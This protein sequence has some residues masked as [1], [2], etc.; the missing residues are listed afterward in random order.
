M[1]DRFLTRLFSY[2]LKFGTVKKER[3]HFSPCYRLR[4]WKARKSNTERK[5]ALRDSEIVTAPHLYSSFLRYFKLSR[6]SVLPHDVTRST[7][8]I[9]TS[10][11]RT[12]NLIRV[13][14][15][16]YWLHTF[17]IGNI[18]RSS[19]HNILENHRFESFVPLFSLPVLL[20]GSAK[21]YDPS[22]ASRR[23]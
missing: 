21:A 11:R 7:T 9:I 16:Y 13:S 20:G 14:G 23:S 19:D 15:F 17:R 22:C 6:L 4:P 3:A 10:N 8:H 2:P 5:C 1:S 18:R 12:F